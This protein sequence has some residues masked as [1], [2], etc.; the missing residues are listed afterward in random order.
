MASL[1]KAKF[2]FKTAGIFFEIRF[3]SFN[4]GVGICGFQ[5]HRLFTSLQKGISSNLCF[6][7]YLQKKEER[8][9]TD[10]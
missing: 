4:A 2:V 8:F 3:V 10:L 9:C 7:F 1:Y 6:K 5:K